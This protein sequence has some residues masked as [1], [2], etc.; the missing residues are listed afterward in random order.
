MQTGR[1]RERLIQVVLDERPSLDA[2]SDEPDP[3]LILTGL[4]GTSRC[5]IASSPAFIAPTVSSV[6][7]V[8][9]PSDVCQSRPFRQ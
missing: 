2:R 6:S 9:S 3:E 5:I 7:V 8:Q 1:V 4:L